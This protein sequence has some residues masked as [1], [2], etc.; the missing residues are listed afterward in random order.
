MY[1]RMRIF[2]DS[3]Y[4]YVLKHKNTELTHF[5]KFSISILEQLLEREFISLGIREKR[6]RFSSVGWLVVQLHT[7]GKD[8]SRYLRRKHIFFRSLQQ[9]LRDVFFERRISVRHYIKIPSRH[10]TVYRTKYFD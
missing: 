5:L 1:I 3:N 10:T 4:H 6:L 7:S 8:R 2:D 9:R